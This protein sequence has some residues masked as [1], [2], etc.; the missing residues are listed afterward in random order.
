[1]IRLVGL[2]PHWMALHLDL[3]E[4]PPAG[5]QPVEDCPRLLEQLD[6]APSLYQSSYLVERL[7]AA[8][9]YVKRKDSAE[10]LEKH[11]RHL[12]NVDLD[13]MSGGYSFVRVLIWAIPT[14]GF[15]GTVIGIAAAIGHL[16]FDGDSIVD[17]LKLVISPLTYA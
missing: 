17:S 7:R 13:R 1:L 16:K 8:I 11:L 6:R 3:L 5:G 2:L 15:L 4:T 14:L 9:D 12:E 10:T